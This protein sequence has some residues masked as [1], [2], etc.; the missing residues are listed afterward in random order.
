[1]QIQFYTE[2]PAARE[3]VYMQVNKKYLVLFLTLNL[4]KDRQ[5]KA[6]KNETQNLYYM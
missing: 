5:L 2:E 1:M 4:F 3:M 6:N